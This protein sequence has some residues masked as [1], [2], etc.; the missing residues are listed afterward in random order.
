MEGRLPQQKTEYGPRVHE[1]VTCPIAPIFNRA[2]IAEA[3]G[4]DQL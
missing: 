4:S 1:G 3:E 2:R